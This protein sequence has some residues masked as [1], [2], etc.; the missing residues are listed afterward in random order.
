MVSGD[1]GKVHADFPARVSCATRPRPSTT[2]ID[3]VVIAA[4]NDAHAPLA[5]AA[6]DA[7]KHVVVDKPFTT[8]LEEARRVVDAAGRNGRIASVFQN[9]RWDSDFL[10]LRES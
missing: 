3:L 2:P 5:I 7:G 4:P 1:A 6:L 8:T 10:T 9:R